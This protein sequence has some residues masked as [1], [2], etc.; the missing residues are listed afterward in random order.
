[1]KDKGE[2]YVWGEDGGTGCLGLGHIQNEVEIVRV[3]N[4]FV[5]YNHLLAT[6]N[7]TF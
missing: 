6:T 4:F 2:L 3:H 7:Q 1:L 5:S